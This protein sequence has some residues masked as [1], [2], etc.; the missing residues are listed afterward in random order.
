MEHY[1]QYVR[2]EL[3][4]EAVRVALDVAHE[5]KAVLAETSE[6][7]ATYSNKYNIFRK[8]L[9]AS[10]KDIP[11]YEIMDYIDKIVVDTGK[12]MW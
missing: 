11:L 8:L 7:K 9:S 3:N 5:A 6:W 2:G 1:E 4:K 10:S 12:K